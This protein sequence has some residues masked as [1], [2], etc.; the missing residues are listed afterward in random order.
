MEPSLSGRF[1]TCTKRYR[2]GVCVC[3]CVFVLGEGGGGAH[4]IR[5]AD[6]DHK[7]DFIKHEWCDCV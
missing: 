4:G 6:I 3:V 5:S 2:E 1:H 7:I